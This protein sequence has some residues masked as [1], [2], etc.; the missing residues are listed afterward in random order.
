MLYQVNHSTF[1]DLVEALM[2]D[3]HIKY[4]LGAKP[5]LNTKPEDIKSS[6][7]SGF[8]RYLLY[9]ATNGH[10][11]FGGG[12]GGTW[13]QN[14]W[15]VDQGLDIVDYSTAANSDSHLRV[16]FIHG[17]GGKIGHVWLILNGLTIESHGGKGA[18]RRD[19]DTASLK[20]GVNVCYKLARIFAPAARVTSRELMCM[21]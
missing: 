19:W 17:G 15:C 9:N 11:N 12:G 7:C 5:G 18:N 13:W 10:M 3:G 6:D 8:V 1:M 21:R 2:K 14:K 16:A 20:N 4:K